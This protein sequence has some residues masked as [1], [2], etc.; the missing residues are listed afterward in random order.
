MTTPLEAALRGAG[1]GFVVRVGEITAGA[2]GGKCTVLVDE[3]AL[4]LHVLRG[5]TPTVGDEVLVILRRGQGYVLGALG[6]A[7]PAPRVTSPTDV[8]P[9]PTSLQ[10]GSTVFRP[11]ST[12]TY[13]GGSWRGDTRDLYQ[14]DWTG[15]GVNRGAAFYGNGP[16]G[17]RG[18]TVT[19]VRV[20]LKRLSGGSYAAQSPTVRLIQEKARAG[21]PNYIDSTGGPSLRIGQSKTFD[22]PVAWGTQLVAGTAGGVG[23]YVGGSAPY[24]ALDGGPMA[25]RIDWKR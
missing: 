11:T 2:S 16:R 20:T 12:G 3:T 25:L 10:T 22:L 7:P 14:G 21:A 9:P 24:V 17:L 15:R 4:K 8:A 19:R 6:T 5:Y 23:I 13:R 18:V 1:R